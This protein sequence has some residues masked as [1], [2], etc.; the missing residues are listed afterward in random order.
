MIRLAF[1]VLATIGAVTVYHWL[2]EPAVSETLGSARHDTT[3]TADASGPADANKGWHSSP[4][5]SATTYPT[6]Q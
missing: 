3:A 5:P 4:R 1:W 6:A 2:A